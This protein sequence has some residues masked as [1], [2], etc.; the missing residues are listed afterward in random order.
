[1]HN[2]TFLSYLVAVTNTNAHY[3]QPRID[4]LGP[5]FRERVPNGYERCSCS[6]SCRYQ[7]FNALRL[8]HFT[9]DRH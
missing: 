9:T 1:M 4:F 6:W 8:F 7:I 5:G 2:A 3:A